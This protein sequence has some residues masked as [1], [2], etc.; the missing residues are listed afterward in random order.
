MSKDYFIG[1]L[2]VLN[3]RIAT[4]PGN[5]NEGLGYFCNELS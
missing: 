4:H 1:K 2:F 5:A 3:Y